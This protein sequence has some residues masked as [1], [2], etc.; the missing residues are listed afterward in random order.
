MVEIVRSQILELFGSIKTAMMESFDDRYAT[1]AEMAAT[2][3]TS[4]VV[5][6][7]GGAGR[8]FLYRDFDNTKPRTF[9]GI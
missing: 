1:L 8:G 5:V 9:D 3:A 7:G 4:A 2:I 6:A